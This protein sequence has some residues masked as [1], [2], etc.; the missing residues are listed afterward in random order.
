MRIV[1][2]TNVL[3]SAFLSSHGSPAEVFRQ[4]EHGLFDLLVSEP[5]LAEY[6]QALTY[7]KVQMRH[8]MSDSDV[9]R[10]IEEVRRGSIVVTPKSTVAL[11]ISDKDDIKFFACAVAGAGEYIVSGD[12]LV[13]EVGAYRGVQVLSPSL[14][15]TVLKESL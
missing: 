11:D 14:F 3:V 9:A 2:D 6:Q 8:Q 5:I 13:Q 1:I 4:Y 12:R 15:L 10:T 7:R